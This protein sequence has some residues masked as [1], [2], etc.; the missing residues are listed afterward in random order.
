M[1]WSSFDAERNVELIM[2][3]GFDLIEAEVTNEEED[4]VTTHFLWILAKKRKT[5]EN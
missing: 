5:E 4:G 1:F 3:A 2:A